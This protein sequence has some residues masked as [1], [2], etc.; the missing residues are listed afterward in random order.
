MGRGSCGGGCDGLM[1][2]DWLFGRWLIMRDGQHLDWCEC[3]FIN[4]AL[5][6]QSVSPVLSCWVCLNFGNLYSCFILHIHTHTH[7]YITNITDEL[8]CIV[9]FV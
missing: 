7:P 4:R 5:S 1:A 9:I 8:T 6:I 2:S 3:S